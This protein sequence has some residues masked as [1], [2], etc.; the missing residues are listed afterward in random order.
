MFT[1]ASAFKINGGNFYDISGDMNIHGGRQPA[2]LQSNPLIA[3][4]SG[5]SNASNREVV[6]GERHGREGEASRVA[7]SGM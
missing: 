1:A 6:V 4:E 7:P 3:L 5:L 2:I